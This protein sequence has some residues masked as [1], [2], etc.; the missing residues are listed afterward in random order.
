MYI[1]T[2]LGVEERGQNI[3]EYTLMIGLIVLVIWVA[4][5]VFGIPGSLQTIWTNV[6]TEIGSA[7]G[8]GS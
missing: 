7:P 8:A 2:R 5:S 4:I 6:N 1:V 3:V